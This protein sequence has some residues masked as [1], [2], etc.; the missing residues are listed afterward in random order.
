MNFEE[1]GSNLG[2]EKDEFIELVELFV[3]TTSEDIN[4]L[5]VAY[6]NKDDNS[7]ARAVHSIKGSSGNLGFIE[8]SDI[9]KKAEELAGNNKLNEAVA[10]LEIMKTKLNEI[11]EHLKKS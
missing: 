5:Q 7:A 6:E 4:K 1:L 8:L 10:T 11:S 3:T 2:L 9:A